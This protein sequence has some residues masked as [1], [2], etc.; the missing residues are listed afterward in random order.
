[1][2]Q[3]RQYKKNNVT[4]VTFALPVEVEGDTIHLMGE[5]N[6]WQT[7]HALR[8][9]KKGNW[10]VTVDLEPGS[11]YQFRYLVDEQRWLNDPEA[12]AYSPNPY[13]EENSVV[14]T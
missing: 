12:D 10:R 1:M 3:K 2:L 9:H 14:I 6:D 8:R 13:G 7:S 4:K 5:F 11:E